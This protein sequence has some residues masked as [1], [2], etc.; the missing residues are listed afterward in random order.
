MP[1]R[2]TL[3]ATCV[4]A[5]TLAVGGAIA[6]SAGSD[7]PAPRYGTAGMSTELTPAQREAMAAVQS[8]APIPVQDETGTPRGFVRDSTL[9]ARDDRVTLEMLE[10]FREA[11]GPADEEYLEL[12][13]ALRVLDPVAVVDADGETVGYW[14]HDFKEI[15]ELEQLTPEA[16]ATVDRLLR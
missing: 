14:T 2:R 10:G 12:F 8:D 3:L 16:Q 5:S 4:A 13:E 6:A 7:A 11:N 1:T 15:D 9:T